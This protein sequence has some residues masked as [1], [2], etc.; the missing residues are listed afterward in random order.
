LAAPRSGTRSRSGRRPTLDE[1][2][3]RAGVG[4]G[5]VSR[6]VN[7]SSQVSEATKATVEQAISELGYVPNRAARALVT[8]RTDAVALVV[9]EVEGRAFGGP[10]LAGVVRGINAVLLQTSLQFWVTLCQST[11]DRDRVL[12]HLT[13][14]HID[15]VL[16]LS[17][18]D[19][20]PL[21]ALLARRGLP[22]VR[23]V[24]VDQLD[25]FG[26]REPAREEPAVQTQHVTAGR[27]SAAVEAG[28][29]MA[30]LLVGHLRTGAAPAV[31]DAGGA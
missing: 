17:V 29:R 5:T 8:Q 15:G 9:C 22:V 31:L 11:T 2:A 25:P 10:F 4:R 28:R 18:S 12:R 1:V 23:L 26:T 14:Q 19:N 20:D 16:F 3:T 30:A 7:G 6:V 21:A 13:P 24:G 27:Q